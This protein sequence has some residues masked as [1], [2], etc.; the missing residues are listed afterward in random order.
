MSDDTH[1]VGGGDGCLGALIGLALAPAWAIWQLCK[2]ARA[3]ARGFREG[4]HHG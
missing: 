4:Y 2:C 3:F 1:Y